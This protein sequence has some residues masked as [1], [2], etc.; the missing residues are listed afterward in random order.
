MFILRPPVRTPP[1]PA[2]GEAMLRQ[3][4]LG[5]AL[6]VLLGGSAFAQTGQINGVITDN[7]NAVLPGATVKVV[8]VSTGLSRE[9]VSGV[10]GRYTL[11]SLR[12]STYDI[13]VELS[14]FRT[15]L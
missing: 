10:D 5:L 4:V 6:G 2:E 8:E 15:A 7:T 9:T 12:P 3:V 1:L 11:T 14:G 13:T